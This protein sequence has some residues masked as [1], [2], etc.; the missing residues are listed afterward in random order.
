MNRYQA[1]T[2]EGAGAVA[3]T[4]K[5]SLIPPQERHRGAASASGRSFCVTS[6]LPLAPTSVRV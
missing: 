4:P 2:D 3:G 5:D 6:G 1:T